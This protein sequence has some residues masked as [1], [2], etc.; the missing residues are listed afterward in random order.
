MLDPR[1]QYA[2]H[3]TSCDEQPLSDKTL[4]RFRKRCYDYETVYGVDLYHDCIKDLSLKLAKMMSINPRIRRTNA[5]MIEANIRHLSRL[6]SIL[7]DADRLLLI[8]GLDAVTE[9][10]LLGRCLSEQTVIE[11]SKRRLRT[12]EDGGFHSGILQN[13]SDPDATFR[14]KAGKADRSG[15]GGSRWGLHRKREP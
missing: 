4:S 7:G 3:T 8:N 6:E 13:P 1:Y 9:Y 10:Q 12:K 15:N 5:L 2:L 14:K 11:G